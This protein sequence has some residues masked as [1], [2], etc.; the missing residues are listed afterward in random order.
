MEDQAIQFLLSNTL[1]FSL[2]CIFILLIK[3]G[4]LEMLLEGVSLDDLSKKGFDRDGMGRIM[5]VLKAMGMVEEKENIFRIKENLRGYFSQNDPFSLLG[6]IR[7]MEEFHRR[8][9]NLG[10]AL[11]GKRL[12]WS[13]DREEFFVNLSRGLFTSNFKESQIFYRML[14]DKG[15]RKVLDVGSGSCVWSIPFAMEGAMVTAIDLPRVNREVA[16]PILENLGILDR[17]RF[18]DGDMGKLEWGGPYDLVIMAHIVHGHRNLEGVKRLFEKASFSL[19]EGGFLAVVEFFKIGVSITPF[20]FDLHMYLMD[21]GRVF[22]VGELEGVLE[23]LGFAK[24]HL[25][26]LSPEKGTYFILALKQT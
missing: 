19:R 2:P 1:S 16:A 8:W 15:L 13:M 17:Y 24:L 23:D 4:I 26:P 3:E 5:E 9:E 12:D 11:K 14:K 6:F 18:I 21:R 20:L 7:N 22:S 25:Y 10:D